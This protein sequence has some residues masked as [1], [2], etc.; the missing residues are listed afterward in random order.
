M[1]SHLEGMNRYIY[2]LLL[3]LITMT[4]FSQDVEELRQKIR[5]FQSV[6]VDSVLHYA[7]QLLSVSKSNDDKILE[8][9]AKVDLARIAIMN[10]K[11]ELAETYLLFALKKY[12]LINDGMKLA[13]VFYLLGQR[14]FGLKN[15]NQA[16]T[17]YYKSLAIKLDENLSVRYKTYTSVARILQNNRDTKNALKYHKKAIKGAVQNK[18]WNSYI[19]TCL[20][21]CILYNGKSTT[22]IDS[23]A[24][25][26]RKAMDV[27]EQEGLNVLL[28]H[29]INIA[30]APIIRQGHNRE[31]LV[32]ARRAQRLFREYK[33]PKES[34]FVQYLNLGF[35]YLGLNKI[36]SAK[37]MADSAF[38]VNP[39][40]NDTNRLR[41]EIAKAEQD[42]KSALQYHEVYKM[43]HDSSNEFQINQKFSRLQ[44]RLEA[45]QKTQEVDDLR[46]QATI[47]SLQIDQQRNLI[48][49]SVLV[50]LILVGG[51]AF[52]MV[53]SKARKEHAFNELNQKL[54]RT[55]MSPHFMFNSMNSIQ[56]FMLKKD[57]KEAGKYLG[58]YGTLMRQI[59]DHSRSDF[60]TLEEE[61]KMLKNY[62][63]LETLRFDG[64]FKY[65]IQ[66]DEELNPGYLAIPP[67]FAQPFVENSLEHGLFKKEDKNWIEV[68]FEAVSENLIKLT[69]KDSGTGLEETV[70]ETDHVSHATNIT[71]ERLEMYSKMIKEKIHLMVTNIKDSDGNKGGLSVEIVLP[72]K[73]M[74][75]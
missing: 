10:Q 37:T 50:I 39:L 23:S 70:A 17:F 48:T 62:L 44:S 73:V 43:K 58:M 31:G 61:I 42:F 14:E 26:G 49:I 34:A 46:Q 74:V 13:E 11:Y 36:D 54:L 64:N 66:M 6:N 56:Q 22:N 25:Y 5:D 4:S 55:Q 33:M 18:D 67:L 69:V 53:W 30:A 32:L 1:K 7:N 27:S 21:L 38:Y 52:Y 12:H 59:L 8:A 16:L 28:A 47:D 65:L 20:N 15:Q 9:E 57:S 51:G 40:G 75:G 60:I 3:L 68:K 72:M 24:Y 29:S 35:A 45:N 71:N 19:R 63:E 41:Y 2:I